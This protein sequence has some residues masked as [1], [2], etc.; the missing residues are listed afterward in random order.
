MIPHKQ[1]YPANPEEAETLAISALGHIAADPQMLGRFLNA[2]GL[3]AAT[4]RAA[5]AEPGFMSAVTGFLMNNEPAL[6]A[7]TANEGLRPEAVSRAHALL[8]SNEATGW[9]D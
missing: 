7:F 5:A 6:L 3:D 9:N 1:A 8:T 4:L 2:T